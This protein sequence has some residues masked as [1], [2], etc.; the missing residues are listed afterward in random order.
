[1]GAVYRDFDQETLDHEYNA[2]ASVD[3]AEYFLRAYAERSREARETTESRPDVAYGD[4]PDEVIDIFSAA[5]GGSPVFIFIH[6]G[7]WRA[8]SQKDSAFMA[9]CFARQGIATVTVNYSLAPGTSLDLIVA[10]CRKAVAWVW[11]NAAS[12]GGD[13]AR[14]FVGGSSAGGHL[15]GMM[16]AG[17]WQEAAGVPG[18]VVKGGVGLSGLY[19]LEPLRLSNVN[20]WMSMDVETAARN[21]PLIQLPHAEVLLIAACG[22][23]ETSEFKRQNQIY[24][25]AWEQ[26][27][28]S[29]IQFEAENRNHFDIVFDMCDPA[30]QLSREIFRMM[31]VG[32]HKETPAPE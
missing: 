6:G 20:D 31:G 5:T 2:R 26:R 23:L 14:I 22:A 7:Y 15:A 12:F 8:L 1:M 10:Q 17:G 29:R 9:P 18:D 21:S 32:R 4:H 13:A 28:W 24:A 30:T 19:D 3:D 25:E 11:H 27:A 16:L